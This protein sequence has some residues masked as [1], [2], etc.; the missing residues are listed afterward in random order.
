MKNL[1][2]QFIDTFT[3][4][5]GRYL[6]AVRH[7]QM[8]ETCLPPAL[9]SPNEVILAK[10]PYGLEVIWEVQW[11]NLINPLR[12]LLNASLNMTGKWN[13]VHLEDGKRSL[14]RRGRLYAPVGKDSL[15]VIIRIK[16][17]EACDE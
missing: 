6:R 16:I 11:A 12:D 7:A 13:C 9:P 5:A 15:P 1:D 14:V 4:K 8:L 10:K 17:V 2:P 3:R